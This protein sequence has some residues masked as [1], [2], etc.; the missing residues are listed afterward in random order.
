MLYGPL[1]RITMCVGTLSLEIIEVSGLLRLAFV[2]SE[3]VSNN[4]DLHRERCD[5]IDG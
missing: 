5:S 2:Q 1:S 3:I 4:E